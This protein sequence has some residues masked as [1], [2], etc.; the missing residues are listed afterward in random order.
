[1]DFVVILKWIIEESSW[2]RKHASLIQ[3]YREMMRK[4]WRVELNLM[5]MEGNHAS[6]FMAKL[7]LESN[8]FNLIKTLVSPLE[9]YGTLVMSG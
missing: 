8:N 3:E 9:G 4:P 6:N 7:S 1:M 5:Y 2:G